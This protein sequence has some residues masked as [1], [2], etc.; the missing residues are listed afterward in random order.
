MWRGAIQVDSSGVASSRAIAAAP[1]R[2]VFAL[3]QRLA[4]GGEMTD[5]FHPIT[6]EVRKN[7]RPGAGLFSRQFLSRRADF[8]TRT[9]CL[10]L[11]MSPARKMQGP[12]AGLARWLT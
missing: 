2:A 10:P 9:R 7:A 5:R 3:G 4:E 12:G 8:P 11:L 1:P 6:P